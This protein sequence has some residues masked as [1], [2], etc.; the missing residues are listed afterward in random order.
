MEI[1]GTEQLSKLIDTSLPKNV[2]H[3]V[4]KI[5]FSHYRHGLFGKITATFK[6]IRRLFRGRYPGYR[7]CNTFYHDLKHTLE[8]FLATA[9]LIDGYNI[10][11]EKLP[12]NLVLLLLTSALYHDVGYIQEEWDN[13]GTGAKY[14]KVHIQRSI[15]FLEKHNGKLKLTQ[16]EIA[17]VTRLIRCTGLS[18]EFN[19]IAFSSEEEKTAGAILGTADLLGQMSDRTY[20][21]KLL[22]LYYEFK[23]AGIEG[24]NTEFDIIKKTID[25]YTITKKNFE[26]VL[27]NAYTYAASHF[28]KRFN[29]KRNLYIEAIDRHIG[30][31]KKIIA[32]DSTNFRNKLNRANWVEEYIY[33]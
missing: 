33:S 20:L 5:F 9:R 3:A 16:E 22:F 14:T 23:E 21:E 31:I 24:Y 2:L 11:K 28:E 7:E 25:F 12:V 15:S 18:S 32:D 30:Y 6:N 1:K 29:I 13:E 8:T 26:T 19:T 17:T 4:K 10:E 27:M